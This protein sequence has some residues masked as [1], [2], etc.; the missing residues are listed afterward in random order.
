[1]LLIPSYSSVTFD[2]HVLNQDYKGDPEMLFIYS[3]FEQLNEEAPDEIK[4]KGNIICNNIDQFK[5]RLE[6]EMSNQQDDV[7][8]F[9]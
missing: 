1:M 2:N 7:K 8:V 9:H 6:E 3:L 5:K 4:N